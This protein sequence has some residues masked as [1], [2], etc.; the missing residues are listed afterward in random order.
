MRDKDARGWIYMRDIT[1]I[2]NTIKTF[3]IIS[4]SRTLEIQT[5]TVAEQKLWVLGMMEL[6]PHANSKY[7]LSL[8]LFIL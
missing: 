1:E 2:S 4:P 7:Y 8:S 3:T 5:S 6:C